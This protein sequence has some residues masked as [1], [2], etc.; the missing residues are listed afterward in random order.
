MRGVQAVKEAG[1]R[2]HAANWQGYAKHSQAHVGREMERGGP[3][4]ET[5]KRKAA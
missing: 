5:G 1:T 3:A 4:K 2:K